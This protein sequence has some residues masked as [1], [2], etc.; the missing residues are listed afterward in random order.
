MIIEITFDNGNR[1]YVICPMEEG[2][3]TG[4]RI[5]KERLPDELQKEILRHTDQFNPQILK[6]SSKFDWQGMWITNSGIF[7]Y[8]DA[9]GKGYQWDQ[10]LKQFNTENGNIFYITSIGLTPYGL[11]DERKRGDEICTKS[12]REWPV[13]FGL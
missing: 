3:I 1:Y 2:K 11:L 13:V 4:S 8:I 5:V 9:E 7:V 12:G 6:K 10:S